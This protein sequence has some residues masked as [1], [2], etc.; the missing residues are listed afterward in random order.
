MNI[1]EITF[2][3]LNIYQEMSLTFGQFQASLKLPCLTGCGRCCL[4]PEIEAS[5]LEMLPFA[6]KIYDE[7]KLE[8]WLE[9]T[10][11]RNQSWCLLFKGDVTSGLG[12]CGH[13]GER[14]AVCRMFGVAGLK[15]KNQNSKLS[16]CKFIREANPEKIKTIEEQNSTQEIPMLSQWYSRISSLGDP[17]MQERIPINQA[18]EEALKKIAFNAQYKSI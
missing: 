8:E 5:V 13:Y 3:L 17:S 14:P 2:N 18:I 11:N 4:N 1:R 10:E 9:Q 6:L 12:Q 16:I 7:G 15:D